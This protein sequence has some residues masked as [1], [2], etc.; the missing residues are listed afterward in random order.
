MCNLKKTPSFNPNHYCTFCVIDL[1]AYGASDA[2]HQER[3]HRG[4]P[5]S[6]GETTKKGLEEKGEHMSSTGPKWSSIST[7]QP[8]VKWSCNC[9]TIARI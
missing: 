5:T 7:K 4:F 6:I 1:L 2:R 9:S 3:V 8:S